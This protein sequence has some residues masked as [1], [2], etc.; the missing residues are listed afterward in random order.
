M[1]SLLEDEFFENFLDSYSSLPPPPLIRNRGNNVF[2]EDLEIRSW[3]Q[4]KNSSDVADPAS[5]N[6]IKFRARFRKPFPLFRNLLVSLC[7]EH[8][9]FKHM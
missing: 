6:G 8:N 3:G 7:V 1:A 9:I 4:L 2:G 5:S